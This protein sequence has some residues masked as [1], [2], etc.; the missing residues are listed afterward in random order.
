MQQVNILLWSRKYLAAVEEISRFSTSFSLDN[1]TNSRDSRD[2][3]PGLIWRQEIHVLFNSGSAQMNAANL[4]IGTRLGAAFG[5][6]LLL[7]TSLIVIGLVRLNSIDATSTHMIESDL[8][9]AEAANTINAAIRANARRTMELFF[10]PDQAYAAMIRGKIENN[11][12]IIGDATATLE[13]LVSSE[14]GKALLVEFKE[15]RS[16]Y[17]ASFSKVDKLISA[18]NR[19]GASQTMLSETLPL[20]DALQETVKNMT[21]LQKSLVD[22][23]GAGIRR[24][25]ASARNQMIGLGLAAL[26]VGLALAYW[27]TRSITRPLN[28]ALDIAQT[29]AAGD[30]TSRIDVTTTDETGQLLQA[31]KN[32]NNS[33]VKIVGEVRVGTE[34]IA[35]ASSEIA[36]G[37]LDLSSRT[38][39]QASSL[40]ETASAMEELT[41]TVKQNADHAR[42]AN[43]L[44]LSASAVAVLGGQ[45]M[46]KVVDTMQEINA[47]AKKIVDIIGVIDGI[48][49]QTNILALNAA[50][51]AARAG[52]QGRGF[53]VVAAEVRNL[54]QRSAAAA[55]EIKQLIG[56]SVEKVDAGGKLV[57][58]AGATMSEVVDSVRLVTDVIGEISAASQA[59]SSGIEQINQAI[60]QMDEVTQQNAALVEQAAASAESLQGQAGHLAHVVSV[61]KLERV[62]TLAS[63]DTPI[64]VT[65]GNVRLASR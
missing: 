59:Q 50:V 64:N 38:E 60:S 25:I 9:K 1:E 28:D 17:V 33:L 56:A 27:I 55:K 49:F 47:S 21:L 5:I 53:A 4:K 39:Q 22:Q 24:D 32:M 52:E 26:L 2:W 45:V 58:Q 20:L 6:V 13:L 29:V 19:D 51:E 43:Q 8:V 12:K 15:K 65:M 41:S 16:R 61:F 35:T 23:G 54:A 44:A 11:K 34:T 63:V 31:L 37:N 40:E 48:A 14:Q 7:M 18:Q 36:S 62:S 57:E 46:A 42:H 30:L 3:L 10:A